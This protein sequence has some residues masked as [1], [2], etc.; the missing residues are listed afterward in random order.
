M[1]TS[2]HHHLSRFTRNWERTEMV[3]P[4]PGGEVEMGVISML[5]APHSKFLHGL[6]QWPY[7][8]IEQ[9]G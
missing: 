5:I 1:T 6:A 3:G 8:H 9:E 4:R 2:G 7:I